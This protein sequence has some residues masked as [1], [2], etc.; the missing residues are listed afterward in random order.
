MYRKKIINDLFLLKYTPIYEFVDA[1]VSV[2]TTNLMYMRL[3]TG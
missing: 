2:L 1:P 3:R